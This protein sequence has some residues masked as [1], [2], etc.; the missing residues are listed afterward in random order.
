MKTE[1]ILTK[2]RSIEVD[3]NRNKIFGIKS[4]IIWGHHKEGG[5]F[6]LLYL[7][8]PKH[9]SQEDFDTLLEH[10]NINFIYESK[11]S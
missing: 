10:I 1:N 6:P 2:L 8:K 9:I 11:T 4:G 7:S 5:S 3:R